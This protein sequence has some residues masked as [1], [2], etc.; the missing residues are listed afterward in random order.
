MAKITQMQDIIRVF[1][2]NG[3]RWM[4]YNEV[5]AQMDKSLFGPNKGG[6]L[7]KRRIVYR[8]MLGNDI[9]DEDATSTPKKFRLNPTILKRGDPSEL[10]RVYS[11]GNIMLFNEG[12]QFSEVQFSDEEMLEDEVKANYKLIFGPEA[13]YFD[14]K[15]RIGKRICDAIV[16]NPKTKRL[17]VVEN[18]LFIHDLYGHI[19]PQII[20]FFNAMRE[21]DTKEKLKYDVKWEE[22]V[23]KDD[24]IE[25]MKC[26]DKSIFDVVVVIDRIGFK[27]EDTEKNISELARHFVG[28][29]DIKIVFREFNVFIDDKGKKIFRV[30]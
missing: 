18:E 9:F 24:V 17:Y 5:Y 3:N 27:I 6:E 1:K 26:I 7:G 25:I 20:E 21:S 4:D 12:R 22:K 2:R 14:I 16:F 8:Y 15:K 30:K 10:E 23:V 28:D 11:T 13:V 29:K 19:V